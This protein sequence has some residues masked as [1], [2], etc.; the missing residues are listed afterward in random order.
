MS[1][2]W[3][4]GKLFPVTGLPKEAGVAFT[5]VKVI[6]SM[7]ELFKILSD[8]GDYHDAL[9]AHLKELQGF[10]YEW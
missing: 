6:N 10:A 4:E 1:W 9:Y 8:I 7:H 2:E 5:H 3:N